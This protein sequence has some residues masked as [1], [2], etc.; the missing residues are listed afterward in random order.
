MPMATDM[1]TRPVTSAPA[2]RARGGL[3]PVPPADPPIDAIRAVYQPIVDLRTGDTVAFEA[4]A[5]GPAGTPLES[6]AALFAS[7]RAAGRLVEL[8]EACRRTALGTAARAGLRA[9]L[10]VNVE[11]DA[12]RSGGV[13]SLQ[14]TLDG[15]AG[16]VPVL[17]VTERALTSRPSDLLYFLHAARALGW[18]IALDDVGADVRSLALMPIVRPDVVKLDLALVQENPSREGAAVIGAVSA[19]CERT[20]ALVLAEGIEHHRHLQRALA[21]G[22]TLGQ[23]WLFGRP[24]ELPGDVGAGGLAA[25][26]GPVPPPPRG[27]SAFDVVARNRE[28]RVAGWPLLLQISLLLEEQAAGLGREA[29][30]V[31]AFQEAVRFTPATAH[32]YAALARRASLVAALGVGLPIEPAPGVR[33]ASLDPDDPLRG[34][35]SVVVLGAHFSAALVA[36][37]REAAGGVR[38]FEYAVTHERGMVA[39][40]AAALLDKVTALS[41]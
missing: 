3:V 37:E 28:T 11:P 21:M 20:G 39:D 10:F 1:K 14:R 41:A 22:A 26:G 23:G 30:V 36:R 17:E 13:A 2:S 5:R 12:L 34:E 40:A 18:R 38:A 35:W 9:P 25:L 16:L 29:V 7:A 24:A 19:E 33:G 15:H 32:R 4:L 27:G 31:G 8:D 6:P